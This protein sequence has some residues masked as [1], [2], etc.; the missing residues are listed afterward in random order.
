MS[1]FLSLCVDMRQE[2]G[3]T[4]AG[5]S[6][7]TGQTGEM[8]RIVDWVSRAYKDIQNKHREWDFLRQ[9]FSFPTIANTST[10]LPS[11]ISLDELNAW[12]TDSIRCYLTV[13]GVTDEQCLTECSWPVFRDR[14]LLGGN[15]S[16]T[17]RPTVFAIKPDKSI[18]F[19]PLPSAS[20]TVVGEYFLRAQTMMANSDEPLIP[21]EFHAIIMWRA[22]MYYAGFEAAPEVYAQADKEY[23][24]LLYELQRDQRPPVLLG[25]PLV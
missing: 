21:D 4:S 8:K 19:W 24:A 17:G 20:Y 3:V 14:Y 18:I 6:A 25:G 23:K 11:A 12:K 10:Y 15:R 5:P 2:A 9:D 22:L 16:Q 1:T 7:V 13:T